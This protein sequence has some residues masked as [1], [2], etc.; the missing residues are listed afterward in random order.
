MPTHFTSGDIYIYHVT[1][2]TLGKFIKNMFN[3]N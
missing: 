3:T 2:I 1:I